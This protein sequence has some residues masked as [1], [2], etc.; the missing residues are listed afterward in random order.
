VEQRFHSLKRVPYTYI[1]TSPLIPIVSPAEIYYRTE[2]EGESLLILHGGWGYGVYPFDRQVGVL[3]TQWKVIIPDRSGY[4]R[5][6]R[7]VHGFPTDFHYLAATE[8]LAFL[9]SLNVQRTAAWGHSDGAVIAAIMGIM[10][11]DRISRLILESFH[12]YRAKN[13]SREF[14]EQLAYHPETLGESLCRKFEVEH[15]KEYWKTIIS[16][17]GKAWLD[18]GDKSISPDD[19]LY[20]GSLPRLLAPTLFIHGRHDPRTEPG[21]LDAVRRAVQKCDMRILDAYHSPHSESA[22]ADLT[23]KIALEFLQRGRQTNS[24]PF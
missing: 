21:E 12:Y 5:S 11:P 17:Q 13:H 15:G 20:R 19:D 8:T 6:T 4:G 1:K 22:T 14:Y 24:V 7:I 2:G 23:T 9:D 16:N 3:R 18:I 10:A